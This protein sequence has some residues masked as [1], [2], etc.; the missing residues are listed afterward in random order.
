METFTSGTVRSRRRTCP[1]RLVPRLRAS[2]MGLRRRAQPVPRDR[3]LPA[4]ENHRGHRIGGRD[5]I[6][7]AGRIAISIACASLAIAATAHAVPRADA[8]WAR[9]TAG[10]TITLD[11][12]LDE[13]AWAKAESVTVY[14]AKENG[15]PGSGWKEEG[16]KLIRDSTRATIKFLT[17]GNQL[18]VAFIVPDSSIGGSFEFNRF[19]GLLMSIKDHTAT[20]RSGYSAG[21]GRVSQ[22][23]P[24]PPS[25]YLYSWWFPGDTLHGKDPGR[26]PCFKDD[27]WGDDGTCGTR[28]ATQMQAW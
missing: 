12:V 1:R 17:S 22:E 26:L 11:G 8:V 4:D 20:P 13:P 6:M 19:D 27:K 16:G 14:Y 7:R 9:N 23:T 25:E 10:A 5:S 15:I 28:T 24:A 21:D 2:L 18:Y 3:R